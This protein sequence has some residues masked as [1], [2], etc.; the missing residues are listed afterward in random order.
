MVPYNGKETVT[1]MFGLPLATYL[2]FIVTGAS[3]VL[4]VAWALYDRSRD[5]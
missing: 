1:P 5:D 2:A 4:A 3:I